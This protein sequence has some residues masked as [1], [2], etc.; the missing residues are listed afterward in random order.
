MRIKPLIMAA[1]ALFTAQAAAFS[2]GTTFPRLEPDPK[3]LEYYR[4]A[5]DGGCSWATLAQISLWASG[6]T[7]A[8][9]LEK[10]IAASETI[11]KSPELP[12]TDKDRAEYIL[13][14]MH[15]NIIKS[16]SLYQTRIDTMLS[17]GRYNCVSSA[18]LYMLLCES[19]GIH[20][21]GVMTKDHALITVHLGELDIDVETTNARGF[22]PG[23]RKEFHDQFGKLTGF[24][25]VPAKN[26]RDRQTI[27][28]IELVSLILSNRI[29]DHERQNRF[30][31]AVPIAIDRAAL[32]MGN[33]L[34]IVSM[35]KTPETIFTDS[36]KDLMDRLF[37]F[38]SALLKAGKEEECL[39]WAAAASPVYPDEERWQEFIMAAV[40]N[41]QAKLIRAGKL[42]DARKFID[43]QRPVLSGVNYDKLDI[44]LIDSELFG[45]AN[46]IRTAEDSDAVIDAVNQARNSGKIP[47]KRAVEIITF[48]V[49]KTAA[50]ISASPARNWRAAIQYMETMLSRLGANRELEQALNTYRSNLVVDYHNRF[51]AEWNKKNFDEAGR[52][53]N[54][55]LAEFPDNRQLLADKQTVIRQAQ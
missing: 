48:A 20:T 11:K 3:A 55:G 18:V 14:F 43:G 15:K 51:A 29:A 8:S 33:N 22:D 46:Q 7:S 2:Q 23:N 36:R 26:Y 49:Q 47:E 38:G 42:A 50:S 16:Y 4:L 41:Y 54:E 34:S 52:I 6:D 13:G 27:S 1:L 39:R 25:Y 32:L 30:T 28:Q 17:G 10:I 9:N 12:E 5:E 35:T 53:L 45:R 19:L 24:A 31:E 40:N 21:S 44:V 37:N